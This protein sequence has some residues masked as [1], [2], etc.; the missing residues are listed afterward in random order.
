LTSKA[1]RRRVA[2]AALNLLA[3]ALSGCEAGLPQPNA[4]DAARLDGR[5]GQTNVPELEHGRTLYSSRCGSCHALREPG[6]EKPDAWREEVHEMRAKKGVRM[7]DDEER[8]ITAY[9][10]S[11]SSR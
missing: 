7:S 4:A 5:F 8:L 1:N 6:S 9:L 11:I 2:C 10:I 3:L